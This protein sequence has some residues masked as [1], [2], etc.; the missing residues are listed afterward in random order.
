MKSNHPKDV[1][2]RHRV[3]LV[4]GEAFRC[5]AVEFEPG[6]WK[7]VPDGK[8]VPPVL[9]VVAVLKQCE[10]SYKNPKGVCLLTGCK[11]LCN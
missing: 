8:Q 3:A 9:E 7:T 4:Q 10:A 6:L 2:F 1:P 5:V 11:C